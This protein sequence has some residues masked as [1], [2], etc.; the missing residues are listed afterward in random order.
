MLQGRDDVAFADVA[1]PQG[2]QL[3]S[4]DANAADLDPAA[5]DVL[6][7]LTAGLQSDDVL[8]TA[9]LDPAF[10]TDVLDAP[11]AGQVILIELPVGRPFR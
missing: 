9:S 6:K 2:I 11:Q 7:R 8:V 4:R 10:A 1:A 3:M 5:S